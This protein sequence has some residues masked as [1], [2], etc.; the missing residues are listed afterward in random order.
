MEIDCLVKYYVF[1]FSF[2]FA[3]DIAEIVEMEEEKLEFDSVIF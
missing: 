2:C 1:D 3:V